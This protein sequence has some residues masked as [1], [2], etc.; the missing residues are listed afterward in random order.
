MSDTLYHQQ[1]P[2]RSMGSQDLYRSP[3]GSPAEGERC[4]IIVLVFFRFACALADGKEIDPIVFRENI[5]LRDEVH[6]FQSHSPAYQPIPSMSPAVVYSRASSHGQK[7]SRSWKVLHSHFLPSGR[8]KTSF[9]E[10][11][12]WKV[13]AVPCG[14]AFPVD[15]TVF[16]LVRYHVSAASTLLPHRSR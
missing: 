7:I 13:D 11:D 2:F 15:S 16:F 6:L 3:K 14:I 8:S 5:V 12:R 4:A 10:M 9:A 1:S